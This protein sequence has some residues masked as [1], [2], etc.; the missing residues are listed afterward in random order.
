M[1]DAEN[2]KVISSQDFFVV[3]FEC[4]QCEYVFFGIPRSKHMFGILVIFNVHQTV[5]IYL[6]I[7]IYGAEIH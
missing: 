4:E 1:N 6:M 3:L 5:N 7:L 2:K